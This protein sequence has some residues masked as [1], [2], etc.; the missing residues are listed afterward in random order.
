MHCFSVQGDVGRLFSPAMSYESVPRGEECPA[1]SAVP[2]LGASLARQIRLS[3]GLWGEGREVRVRVT[4][5]RVMGVKD[6]W[7]KVK[8]VAWNWGRLQKKV[9]IFGNTGD[10]DTIGRYLYFQE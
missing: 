6:T 5:G 8:Q 1:A 3:T 9:M 4:H 10:Y 7:R 2:R